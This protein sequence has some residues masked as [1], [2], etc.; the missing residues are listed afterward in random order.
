[1]DELLALGASQDGIQSERVRRNTVSKLCQNHAKSAALA[2]RAT[3]LRHLLH[4]R[5]PSG[6]TYRPVNAATASG[7][8]RSAEE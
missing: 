7:V 3:K 2:F 4:V 5:M 8:E 1:M 6:A